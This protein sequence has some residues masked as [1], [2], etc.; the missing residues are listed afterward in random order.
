MCGKRTAQAFVDEMINLG[1]MK[2]LE[3][4]SSSN[5][6]KGLIAKVTCSDILEANG[7]EHMP[8]YERSPPTHDCL[9]CAL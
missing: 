3:E 7:G 1:K 6:K 9:V 5:N 8:Q 4:L 2:W